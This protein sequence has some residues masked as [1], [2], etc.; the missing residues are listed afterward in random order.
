MSSFPPWRRDFE[1]MASTCAMVRHLMGLS[2]FTNTP[3]ASTEVR[4]WVGL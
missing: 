4:I 1:K 3:S 2:L